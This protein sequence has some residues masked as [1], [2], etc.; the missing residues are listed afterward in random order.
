MTDQSSKRMGLP[1]LKLKCS[2]AH[3]R[4]GMQ[5]IEEALCA[6]LWWK[7]SVTEAAFDMLN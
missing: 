5:S 4:F 1:L 7:I 6:E 3:A 2:E